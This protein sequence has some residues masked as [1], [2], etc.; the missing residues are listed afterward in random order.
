MKKQ[1]ERIIKENLIKKILIEFN[2]LAVDV[3]NIDRIEIIFKDNKKIVK[4]LI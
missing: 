3:D 4:K 2:T 1:K